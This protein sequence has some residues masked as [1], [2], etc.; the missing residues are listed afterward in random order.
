M[1]TMRRAPPPLLDMGRLQVDDRLEQKAPDC[2]KALAGDSERLRLLIRG[3][4]G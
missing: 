4:R 1:R 2:T 3:S